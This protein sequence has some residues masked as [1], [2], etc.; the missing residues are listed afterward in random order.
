MPEVPSRDVT[1]IGEGQLRL[2]TAFGTYLENTGELSV[3]VA[4]TE[5]NVLGLLARLGNRT[6]LVTALPQNQLGRRVHNEYK[7]AG[8]DTTAIVWRPEGRL[9]LYFVEQSRSPVP[10][11]VL[12][13]R[14]NSC[15]ATMT[16]EAVDWGY[17]ADGRLLHLTGITAA[18]GEVTY[19]L[20]LR[21]A[22]QAQATGQLLSVDVNHRAHLWTSDVARTLLTP[23]VERADVIFCSRRDALTLWHLTGEPPQVAEQ[24]ADRT[25]AKTVLVSNG[26]GPIAAISHGERLTANPPAAEIVDRVG[27]GD[28][29]VGGFL[30]GVL[31]DDPELGLR[32]GVAAAALALSRRG[33]QVRTSLAELQRLSQ[34]LSHD[35]V[36]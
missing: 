11:S 21:A 6:G 19:G 23:V 5:G 34:S 15:F 2:D 14:S 20:V 8:I 13:D 22:Q 25:G 3:H 9:A 26:S 28:A 16:A 31:R 7:A 32:L 4:G 27:A 30:H 18:L 29:L 10:T 36:R 35:I 24:L 17:L 1:S 33:D 12:Y